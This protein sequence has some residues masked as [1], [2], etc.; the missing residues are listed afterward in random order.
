MTW[1]R[2]LPLVLLGL[3]L[4]SLATQP[5]SSQAPARGHGAQAHDMELVG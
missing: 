2:R 5:A 4:V 3:L 1:P